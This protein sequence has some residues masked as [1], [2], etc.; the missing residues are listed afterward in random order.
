MNFFQ[1][2]ICVKQWLVFV[3]LAASGFAGGT[4]ISQLIRV[5]GA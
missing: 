4:I 3:M 1:K 5:F 2:S